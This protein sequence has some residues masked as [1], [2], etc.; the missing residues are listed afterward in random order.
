MRRYFLI[1][2]TAILLGVWFPASLARAQGGVVY[3]VSAF[4]GNDSNNGRSAGTPFK[5]VTKVNSLALQPGDSVLFK[6][7]EVWRA[8][9]LIIIASG[10]SGKPITFGSYPAADCADQPALSGSQPISGWTAAQGSN[11]YT[12][13][14]STG[15]NA[16]KF[17]HGIN[18]LF[19]N[20]ERLTLGRWPNLSAGYAQ[21]DAQPASNQLTDYQLPAGDW[22]GAALHIKTIRWLLLNRN[23]TASS[24]TTLTVNDN[25][26]CWDGTCAGWGYFLNNH[27]LTLDQD[28]EWYYDPAANRVYLVSTGG[29]PAGIE[30]SAVLAEDDR[31][32]GGVVLGEDAKKH[33]TYVTIKNLAV[34]NWYRHGITTPTNLV[35]AENSYLTIRNNTIRNVEAAGINLAVWVYDA[36]D[37]VN[38]WRG[39]HH[40]TVSG[41]TI[42][43]ANYYGID[44]YSVESTFEN[45]AIRNI[46][47]IKNLGKNGLGCDFT[48][49]TD[50]ECTENG[51]GFRIK[52]DNP[53][54]SARANVLR[55]NRLSRIAYNGVDVFGPDNL[56]DRNV[57]EEAC[58]TKGDCG[59]VR[60]F[61]RSS[62]DNTD[63][64]NVT[65]SNNLIINPIGNTDGDNASFKPLFGM[66]LYIDNYSRDVTVSGNT[67]ISATVTGILYQN[68][69]GQ[70]VGNTLY[71]NGRG[72]M[73]SPQVGLY[74]SATRVSEM[75][76]N[77][78]FGL[79]ANARTLGL[80]NL[81]R[82]ASSNN[83]YFFHPYFSPHIAANGDKT[84]AQWRT[85]SGH[86]GASVEHW[87]TQPAGQPPRSRIFYNDTQTARTIDLGAT[88]WLDLAQNAVVGSIT[89]QPFSSIILVEN[90]LAGLTLQS[91]SPVMWGA[92]E[93][94][95]FTLAVAGSGF[96]AQSVVRWNGA[97]RPTQFVSSSRLTAAISAADV[98]AAG[99]AQVTVYD[100]G[101]QT[102]AL[103]FK[104]VP[105]LAYNYLPLIA[106]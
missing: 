60:T 94:A 61:G 67:V 70:I 22:R 13:N 26:S 59:G 103:P 54:H 20:D 74:A 12:A 58:S 9:P 80:D 88:A 78:L 96:T 27:R 4:T 57:I 55:Y 83:N 6:C 52:L 39:G 76:G 75:R 11:I 64:R 16:G 10:A 3:Y 102:A 68:S 106:K 18:Q 86:D 104:I 45:N 41:N 72:T 1:L 97:A 36:S 29:A 79:N 44:T 34:K 82:L 99:T 98:S 23:V 65:I 93:A 101:E 32:R 47:L 49:N 89:L 50:N 81:G 17:P 62:L 48:Y 8:D 38:G 63:V 71:N 84:L 77:I 33:I 105:S 56:L 31:A 73:V 51:D 42:D 66:G 35:A 87:Y 15:A 5:S 100:A 91:I 40:L 46:G 14:L 53:L 69:T 25:L 92:D 28:G 24:G 19:R 37:G 21:V 43:G 85:Y 30:G 90:G 95:D 7:G 2:I